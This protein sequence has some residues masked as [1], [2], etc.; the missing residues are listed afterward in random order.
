MAQVKY[1]AARDKRRKLF[2]NMI[3]D[4]KAERL[5]LL[6]RLSELDA[7]LREYGVASKT[8]ASR[9]PKSAARA[10]GARSGA[11]PTGNAPRKNSLKDFI[12]R[13]LGAS[14]MTTKEITEAVQAAGYSTKSKT[15]GQSVS[16]ACGDLARERFITKIGRGKYSARA[17]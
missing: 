7:E 14:P 5:N 11:A 1:P 4:L 12:T 17:A 6:D 8:S 10:A 15:L 9:A 13:V 16:V 3:E 2:Q